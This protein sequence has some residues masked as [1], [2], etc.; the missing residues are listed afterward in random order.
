[1]CSQC[2]VATFHCC[3]ILDI[4]ALYPLKRLMNKNYIGNPITTIPKV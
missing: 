4:A 3:P 2:K 1:M